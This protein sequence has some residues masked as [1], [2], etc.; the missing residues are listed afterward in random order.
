MFKRILVPV[1]GSVG[2]ERAV[3]YAIG[4]AKALDTEVIVCHVI[5]S[6]VTPNAAHEE[7]D[8]AQ[9]VTQVAERF[10]QAGVAVKTLVRRGEPGMEIKRAAVDWNVDAIVMATRSRQR[11]QKL[12]LG[13]VADV[14]VRESRLPVLL[15]S[16]KGGTRRSVR[17]AAA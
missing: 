11:L 1:D 6:P 16:S 12:M 5:T 15:V 3:P 13:S 7:R 9:Y 14:I 8:A 17:E 10:R 4:L 2:S